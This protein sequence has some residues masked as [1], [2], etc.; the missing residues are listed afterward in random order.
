[1]KTAL[2]I[3]N[4]V[5]DQLGLSRASSITNTGDKTVTQMLSLMN[6]TGQ[7]LM[8]ET[9]YQFLAAETRFSTVVKTTYTGDTTAGSNT[10]T[11]LSSVVGLTTD[12]MVTGTGIQ[13]DTFLT[14]VGSTTATLSI[15]AS[16][17]GTGVT[18]TFGQA[19]YSVPA[20]YDRLE[21]DTIFNKSNRWAVLGPRNAQ[22]WQWIKSSYVTAGPMMRF[23]IMQNRLTLW[24]MPS[25]VLTI[26]YEYCSKNW[27][28]DNAGVGK[29]EITLDTDTSQFPDILMILGTKYRFQE[30]K[31]FDS[32]ASFEA[33]KR[34]ESKFIAQNSGAEKLNLAPR[35]ADR[36]LTTANLPDSGFGSNRL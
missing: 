7:T 4:T 14:A 2:A 30:A 6:L 20:D 18:F 29:A 34:E 12:F 10:I 17:T 13:T 35:A 9:D 19:K 8:T 23:R 5:L 25:T 33:Y 24:P 31:G 11:N 36:L 26:G 1:M 15:P 21:N 32:S 3:V 22:E 16:V 27:A 28:L